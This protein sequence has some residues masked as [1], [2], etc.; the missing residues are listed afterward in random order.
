MVRAQ[1]ASEISH[2]LSSA[3]KAVAENASNVASL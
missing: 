2:P 1:R 3:P